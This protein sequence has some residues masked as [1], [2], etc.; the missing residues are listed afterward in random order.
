MSAK[1]RTR[2]VIGIVDTIGVMLAGSREECVRILLETPGIGEAPGPA[3]LVG[4]AKRASLLD[5]ALINGVAAHALDYDDFST[6]LGVHYSATLVAPLLALAEAEGKTGADLIAAYVAGMETEIRL[7][8]AVGWQHY[9]KGWHPTS[10]MGTIGVAAACGHMMGLGETALATALGIA[11]SQSAGMKAN[12]GTMTKPLHVGIAARAGLLSALLARRGF[13]ANRTAFEH[14]QGFFELYSG[15]GNYDV[16]VLLA[17]WGAPWE[18]ETDGQALKLWPCCGSTHAA[19][20]AALDLREAETITV[21]QIARI[22]AMPHRRRLRHTDTPHPRTSL[23]GKFSV[24]Y[25]VARA[26]ADGAVTLADFA[27][28][29]VTEPRIVRLLDLLEA[30]GHP[31]MDDDADSQWAAEV[32]V[33]TVDGR[34]LACRIDNVLAN[35]RL[36]PD[37]PAALNGKF[38]DCAKGVLPQDRLAPLFQSLQAIDQA[39]DLGAIGRLLLAPRE[40]AEATAA[41]AVTA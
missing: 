12:F 4:H 31:D 22:Q 5:A 26:L 32:V 35:G 10:T 11:A 6:T 27:P 36:M 18:L 23:E 29:R 25:V 37:H 15:P 28:A 1:A 13:T 21:E 38:M 24:Q 20:V 19:I 30:K 7:A 34:R 33:D 39:P 41:E 9:D 16:D 17:A 3:V 8:R 14:R 2:A 40:A